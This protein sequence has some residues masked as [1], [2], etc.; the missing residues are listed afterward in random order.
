MGLTTEDRLAILDL[1]ARYNH[2]YDQGDGEAYADT[3][4]ED[5]VF[6][7]ARTARGR[8]EL[9]AMP[10]SSAERGWS[11]RHW[12]ANPVID[13]DGDEATMRLYLTVL[14][15]DADGHRIDQTGIYTDRL[16]RVQGSWKFVHRHLTPD[17][18]GN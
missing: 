4:T 12:T 5:G 16:R 17:G 6:E 13:G 2:A 10:Q 18:P 7:G 1:I 11:V 9:Q 14:R 8:A 3:W 15:I